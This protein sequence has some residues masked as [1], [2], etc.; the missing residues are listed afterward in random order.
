MKLKKQNAIQ[1][2]K[3]QKWLQ[4]FFLG[5]NLESG[6]FSAILPATIPILNCKKKN[7]HQ[8]CYYVCVLLCKEHIYFM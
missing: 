5:Q 2:N 1:E 4:A 8:D 6:K 3:L 7:H